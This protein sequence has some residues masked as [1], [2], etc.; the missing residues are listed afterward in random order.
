MA[1]ILEKLEYHIRYKAT[2]LALERLKNSHLK[3]TF[4]RDDEKILIVIE[5]DEL[6]LGEMMQLELDSSIQIGVSD[7]IKKMVNNV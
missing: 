5:N 6:P 2:T 3:Y 4:I 7:I 1:T